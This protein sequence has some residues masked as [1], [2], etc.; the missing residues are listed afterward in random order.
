MIL[1]T[2]FEENIN[3]SELTQLA[4]VASLSVIMATALIGF[5]IKKLLHVMMG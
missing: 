5:G 1:T 3:T 2:I 4:M